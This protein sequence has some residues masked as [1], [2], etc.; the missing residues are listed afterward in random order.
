VVSHV[1]QYVFIECS[2]QIGPI[3]KKMPHREAFRMIEELFELV[4]TCSELVTLNRPL[5]QLIFESQIHF[6]FL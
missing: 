4:K 1:Q 6:S 2:D 3:T 5:P